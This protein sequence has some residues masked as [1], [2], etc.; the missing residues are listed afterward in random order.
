MEIKYALNLASDGRILSATYPKYAPEDAVK[1]DSLPEG[2]I[3]DYRYV[4]GE[5]IYDPIPVQEQPEETSLEDRVVELEEALN[6][7]LLGVT[8]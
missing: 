3:A 6:M 8:E 2:N 7:I 5:C 4:D 1:V